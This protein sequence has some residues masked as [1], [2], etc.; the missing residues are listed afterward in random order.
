M[1]QSPQQFF[2]S[3]VRMHHISNPSK[4]RRLKRYATQASVSGLVKTGKPG[5][6]VFEGE[7]TAIKSFLEN[8]KGL[9]YL[10]FHHLDTKPL[11][12]NSNNNVRL[13]DSKLGLHEVENMNEL[14]EALDTIGE[15][16]W[17]RQQM[18]MTRET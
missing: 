3:L 18:G 8:A 17:F 13:A 2:I 11:S 10:D 5:V 1:L 12:I 15:K 6:V 9:R 7:Q 16:Q 4:F 14:V